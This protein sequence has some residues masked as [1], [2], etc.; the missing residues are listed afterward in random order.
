MSV[1]FQPLGPGQVGRLVYQ[2]IGQNGPI[3]NPANIRYLPPGEIGGSSVALSGVPGMDMALAAGQIA[4]LGLGLANLGLS[5]AILSK[6]GE[7]DRRLQEV[8]AGVERIERKTDLILNAV[9]R[10]DVAT[11]EQN[12]RSALQHTIRRS[13][14]AQEVNLVPF[15]TLAVDIERFVE[16]LSPAEL[17]Y[18]T[19][20]GLR[21]STDV[22][23]MLSSVYHLLRGARLQLLGAANRLVQVSPLVNYS[24]QTLLEAI[25]PSVSGVLANLVVRRFIEQGRELLTEGVEANSWFGNDSA[26]QVIASVYAE[27]GLP[28]RVDAGFYLS[29]PVEN[30]LA[31]TLGQVLKLPDLASPTEKVGKR[32][33]KARVKID[34]YLAEWWC[35]DAALL[36]KTQ[37]EIQL[38]A[39]DEFWD[40]VR[41]VAE[42][43]L[44]RDAGPAVPPVEFSPRLAEQEISYA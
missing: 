14:V 5:V 33:D 32:I 28:D 19:H 8:Q 20:P 9:R 24:E 36:Y 2:V 35:S 30:L 11:A 29:G 27:G 12:L 3:S 42:E 44:P 17:T 13:I 7:M 10:I 41:Q 25:R 37:L 6:L 26:K 31:D 22:R 38:R 43:V 23:D 4:N 21:F 15:D 34:Q 16:S 18:G 1:P 40:P 39:A